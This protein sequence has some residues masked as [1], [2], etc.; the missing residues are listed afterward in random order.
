MR[1]PLAWGLVVLAV[2]ATGVAV[3]AGN[4]F[5]VA[6]PSAGIAVMAASLLFLDVEIRR[7]ARAG[8]APTGISP[9][10]PNQIRQAFLS[11]QLGREKL[12]GLLDRLERS[13]P[14]PTLP[15]RRYEELQSIVAMSRTEFQQ[16]LTA[17]LEYLEART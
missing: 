11:G 15:P 7:P 12:V 2:V 9:T 1:N 13:G 8:R 3:W 17:R 10:Q 4:N 6:L 16:Y 14:N 5:T